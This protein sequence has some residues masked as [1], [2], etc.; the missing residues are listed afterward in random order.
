MRLSAGKL[1]INSMV[2][3]GLD[4]ENHSKALNIDEKDLVK[5]YYLTGL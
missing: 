1:F 2:K 3:K 5:M 4:W